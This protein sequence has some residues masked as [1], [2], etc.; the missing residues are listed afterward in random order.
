MP[1]GIEVMCLTLSVLVMH[2]T[3]G[4]FRTFYLKMNFFVVKERENALSRFMR[5]V[6]L[7]RKLAVLT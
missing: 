1:P 5:L 2:I 6:C 3:E 7:P 4:P